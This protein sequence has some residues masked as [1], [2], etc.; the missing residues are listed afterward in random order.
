MVSITA[1][2]AGEGIDTIA[3]AVRYNIKTQHLA[4]PALRRRKLCCQ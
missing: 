1:H 4:P 2:A 3:T